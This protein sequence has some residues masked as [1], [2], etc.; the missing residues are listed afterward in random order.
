ML[1]SQQTSN[2]NISSKRFAEF[3]S[4]L[5][6]NDKKISPQIQIRPQS[7]KRMKR[8]TPSQASLSNENSPAKRAQSAKPYDRMIEQRSITP[9]DLLMKIFCSQEDE[10]RR[11]HD[12]YLA[13]VREVTDMLEES[14]FLQEYQKVLEIEENIH[15]MILSKMNHLNNL[16]SLIDYNYDIASKPNSPN[17]LSKILYSMITEPKHNTCDINQM[18]KNIEKTFTNK[19]TSENQVIDFSFLGFI[20]KCEKCGNSYYL[21]TKNELFICKDCETGKEPNRIEGVCLMIQCDSKNISIPKP[22]STHRKNTED[23]GLLTERSMPSRPST[24]R[25]VRQKFSL[26]DL[27]EDIETS[28]TLAISGYGKKWNL[29]LGSPIKIILPNL[30]LYESDSFHDRITI[31]NKNDELTA[32]SPEKTENIVEPTPEELLQ[33]CKKMKEKAKYFNRDILSLLENQCNEKINNEELSKKVEY[34]IGEYSRH[35]RIIIRGIAEFIPEYSTALE[36]CLKG[37]FLLCEWVVG[38]N[39]EKIKEIK[40]ELDQERVNKAENIEAQ[41]EIKMIKS[42]MIAKEKKYLEKIDSLKL[43]KRKYENIISLYEKELEKHEFDKEK[44]D[45]TETPRPQRKTFIEKIDL[46]KEL[47]GL[48]RSFVLL[49][50][51]MKK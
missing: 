16:I 13:H 19:K 29:K 47:K 17:F 49:N 25:K 50:S 34:W 43:V 39:N 9:N 36:K 30:M 23:L 7:F 28:N 22:P 31:S 38:A 21:N 33:V 40:L 51:V 48:K 15:K 24:A 46:E 10:E 11:K 26:K 8:F 18:T 2:L 5:N 1:K 3:I 37:I 14:P 45:I 4:K 6:I 12:E 20:E 27:K 44:S 42:D 35:L 32:Y 41:H